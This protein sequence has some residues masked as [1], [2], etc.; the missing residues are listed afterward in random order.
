M[1]TSVEGV[2]L[3][4]GGGAGL[5]RACALTLGRR[6]ARVAVHY[7]KSREGAEAIVAALKEAGTDAHA[8]Q[9]DLAKAIATECGGSCGRPPG[10]STRPPRARRR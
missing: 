4:T 6:G 5:G 8:F 1:M 10:S 9:G 3:V 7:R 2:A